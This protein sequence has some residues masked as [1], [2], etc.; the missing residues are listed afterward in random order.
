M[1]T[2]ASLVKRPQARWG[3][4][5]RPSAPSPR[6]DAVG[7]GRRPTAT[8]GL[9]SRAN[10]TQRACT[11]YAAVTGLRT[12][13]GRR[14][15]RKATT[16]PW[17]EVQKV[18]GEAMYATRAPRRGRHLGKEVEEA[19]AGPFAAGD[20]EPRGGSSRTGDVAL[21]AEDIPRA[22]AAVPS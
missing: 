22:G 12:V 8:K 9:A 14:P 3:K 17:S 15:R 10:S 5:N 7:E 20:A 19:A 21:V 1:S 18:F 6:G 13:D 2:E 16:L 11:S 4:S